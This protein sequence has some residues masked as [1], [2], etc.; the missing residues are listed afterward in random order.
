MFG[1]SAE[2]VKKIEDGESA[3]LFI[4]ATPD[5]IQQLKT[6][7]MVDVYSIG[8]VASRREIHFTAAV[9][10]SENMTTARGFLKF[11]KSEP[12]R[13]VFRKYGLTAP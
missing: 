7:G 5:E 9:V 1:V 2:Q 8:R 12:A 10:A 11:L 4:T 13:A 3:D 6:K